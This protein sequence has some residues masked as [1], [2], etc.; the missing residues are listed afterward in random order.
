MEKIKKKEENAQKI[1][2]SK[3][4]E[5]AIRKVITKTAIS[6]VQ[7]TDN[8]E[9]VHPQYYN[10]DRLK[11]IVERLT[12]EII[13][14][15]NQNK[16]LS[17]EATKKI[18]D[19]KNKKAN[20]KDFTNKSKVLEEKVN[21][22]LKRLKKYKKQLTKSIAET[23]TNLENE[24][25]QFSLDLVKLQED[26]ENLDSRFVKNIE[27]Q[28]ESVNTVRDLINAFKKELRKELFLYAK[29]SQIPKEI[30]LDAGKNV[31]IEVK[32]DKEAIYYTIHAR[33][34]SAVLGGGSS[35]SSG[36]VDLS[37][38]VKKTGDTMTGSLILNADPTS[39]LEAATKQYVDSNN[40]T[41]TFDTQENI[42]NEASPSAGDIAFGTDSGYLYIYDGSNWQ[43]SRTKYNEKAYIYMGPGKPIIDGYEEK[44]IYNKDSYNFA[45]KSSDRDDSGGIRLVTENGTDFIEVYLTD[46]WKKLITGF[47]ESYSVYHTP[48]DLNIYLKDGDSLN[49]RGINGLPLIQDYKACMGP[50][51]QKLLIKSA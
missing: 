7:L 3:K 28:I 5:N 1:T 48:N 33:G 17:K 2:K 50:S 14:L 38:L 20:Q 29:T 8:N 26:I 47:I 24:L 31:K 35:S 19:L 36:S 51:P 10:S 27:N 23:D 13:Q 22:L 40:T 21:T 41:I 16:K 49:N 44:F 15:S 46:S 45:V 34:L 32:E 39:A 12:D 30:I 25:N 42:L 9:D 18:K 6:N 4:L 43:Q 37:G 11:P